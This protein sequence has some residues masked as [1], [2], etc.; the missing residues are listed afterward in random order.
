[1]SEVKNMH[2]YE[3][4]KIEEKWQKHWLDNKLFKTKTIDFIRNTMF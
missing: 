2:K 1:M 3:H 4:R